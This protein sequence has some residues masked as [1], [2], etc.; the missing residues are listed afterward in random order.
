MKTTKKI[1]IAKLMVKIA[2]N[3]AKYDSAKSFPIF[4]YEV[5]K[6]HECEGNIRCK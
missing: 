2:N 3:F 5:Q 1:K 6:P 4:S